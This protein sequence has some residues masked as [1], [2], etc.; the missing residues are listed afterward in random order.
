MVRKDEGKNRWK[1]KSIEGKSIEGKKHRKK[2]NQI[3]SK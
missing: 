2:E 3:I 1:D